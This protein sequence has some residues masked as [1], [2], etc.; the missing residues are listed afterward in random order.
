MSDQ[1]ESDDNAEQA[2]RRQIPGDLVYTT[3]PGVLRTALNAIIRAEQPERFSLDFLNTVLGVKGG[4]GNQQLPV[5]K[6]LGFLRPDGA[7]TEIY[8]KFRSD[9]ARGSAAY[10]A[11]KTGYNSLF[12]RNT[13]VYRATAEEVRDLIVQI[14][15]LKRDDAIVGNIS[16]T[17]EVVR[18]FIPQNFVGGALI[19]AHSGEEEEESPRKEPA[20]APAAPGIGLA[21]NINIVLPPSNSIE[22]YNLI[23]RSLRENILDW[24]K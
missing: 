13:H 20:Q 19:K 1:V 6:R 3:T 15:G 9:G 7:P 21:Y 11:L 17:F 14:T 10:D 22:T 12:Q 8:S 2:K 23:F 24:Q 5:L 16:S 18:S 4:S